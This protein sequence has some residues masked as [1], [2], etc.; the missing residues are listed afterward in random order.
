MAADQNDA[1]LYPAGEA[2]RAVW[3]RDA[4]V[5]LY[6]P[7]GFHP[8]TLG[9]YVAALVMF[10]QLT[11]G[12]ASS[13]PAAV[14]TASGIVDISSALASTLQAAATEANAQYARTALRRR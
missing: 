12:D 9:S 5:E 3:R 11:G 2:W 7:D 8:S 10:E 4:T 13:L 14:P 1:I 6:G